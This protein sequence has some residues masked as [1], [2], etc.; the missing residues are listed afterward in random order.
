MKNIFKEKN[1]IISKLQLAYL[2]FFDC[3]SRYEKYK[4]DFLNLISKDYNINISDCQDLV[5]T[6]MNETEPE[7]S[8]NLVD[9]DNDESEENGIAE[10]EDESEKKSKKESEGGNVGGIREEEGDDTTSIKYLLKHYYKK[11][12]LVT[13][14]DKCKNP[15][16][17][18]IFKEANAAYKAKDLGMLLFI[19]DYVNINI[20][21]DKNHKKEVNKEIGKTNQKSN[22]LKKTLPWLY[23]NTA[24]KEH[25][26]KIIDVFL[27]N[28]PVFSK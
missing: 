2:E 6:E 21:L 27:K 3:E 17:I 28:N 16:M 13:H 5:K 14:P 15:D 4:Q 1:I 19:A 23:Y 8:D 22:N 11:I 26:Q 18:P 7:L 10:K 12:S 24:N 25:K 20:I 9:K